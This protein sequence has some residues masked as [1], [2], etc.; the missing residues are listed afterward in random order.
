MAIMCLALYGIRAAT[1][2]TQWFG[3]RVS[4]IED[5]ISGWSVP[6]L[7]NEITDRTVF[8]KGLTTADN[9]S[10]KRQIRPLVG[11]KAPHNNKTITVK[12]K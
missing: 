11:E 5:M 1:L 10:D 6:L 9:N 2:A 7:Y 8:N 4:T 12:Q 3:E